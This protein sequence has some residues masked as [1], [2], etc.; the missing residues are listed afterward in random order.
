MSAVTLFFVNELFYLSPKMVLL[1]PW[2]LPSATSI[3]MLLKIHI[4]E[5]FII[6]KRCTSMKYY[7]VESGNLSPLALHLLAES[8]VPFMS[9]FSVKGN[10]AVAT[11]DPLVRIIFSVQV[12]LLG[13]FRGQ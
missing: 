12:T 10:L 5:R 1:F 3:A 11:V 13:G 4:G 8:K 9:F 6:M 7:E 2:L